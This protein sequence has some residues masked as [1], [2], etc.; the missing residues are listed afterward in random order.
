MVECVNCREPMV[1]QHV[2]RWQEHLAVGTRIC[3]CCERFHH[4]SCAD[5]RLPEFER[6]GIPY[7]H[8]SS[9]FP[10]PLRASQNSTDR[11][12]VRRREGILLVVLLQNSLWS[13]MEV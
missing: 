3:K 8:S 5:E 12:R 7:L 6:A 11:V 10:R 2:Q 9:A 1:E 4:L 13:T